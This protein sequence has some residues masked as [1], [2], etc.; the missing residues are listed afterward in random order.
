[1]GTTGKQIAITTAVLRKSGSDS[2]MWALRD[3][4]LG[5]GARLISKFG[6]RVTQVLAPLSPARHAPE[7]RV[8]GLLFPALCICKLDY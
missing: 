2:L 3:V 1:M 4:P 8:E 7:T 6:C 5:R